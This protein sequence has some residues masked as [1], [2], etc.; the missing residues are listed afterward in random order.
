MAF[1]QRFNAVHSSL[2][3]S[4]IIRPRLCRRIS[5]VSGKR[6]IDFFIGIGKKM[7]LKAVYQ[8]INIVTRREQCGDDNQGPK[9]GRYA[10]A[11]GEA[12]NNARLEDLSDHPIQDRKSKLGRCRNRKQQENG[13]GVPHSV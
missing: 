8:F 4:I 2:Q 10:S 9:F 12:R 3:Q 6:K 5:P 11:K 7:N 1:I 13:N